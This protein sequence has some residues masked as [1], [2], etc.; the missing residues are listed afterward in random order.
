MAAGILESNRVF[1]DQ[2]V[3]DFPLWMLPDLSSQFS[4]LL[5]EQAAT[6]ERWG[7][8]LGRLHPLIVHFPIGLAIAAAAVE[9]MNEMPTS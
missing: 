3:T 8:F 6:D 5:G 1:G 4:L 7:R 9:L 2:R